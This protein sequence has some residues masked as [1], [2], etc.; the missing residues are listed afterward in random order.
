MGEGEEAVPPPRELGL[1][2][3]PLLV[4]QSV[5]QRFFFMVD[6]RGVLFNGIIFSSL[7][8]R[9]FP[10]GHSAAFHGIGVHGVRCADCSLLDDAPSG[11]RL[12]GSFCPVCNEVGFVGLCS[13]VECSTHTEPVEKIV[14]HQMSAHIHILEN[15]QPV[16]RTLLVVRILL[17]ACMEPAV[18]IHILLAGRILAGHI[19]SS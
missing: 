13:L 16:V 4:V 15:N 14:A 19:L 9:L 7:L 18:H 12:A 3:V 5:L 11:I 2:L 1:G 10:Y 6:S 8:F 17:V